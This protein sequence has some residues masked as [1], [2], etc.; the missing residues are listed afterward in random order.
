MIPRIAHRQ[1]TKQQDLAITQL[2]MP[3]SV[4]ASVIWFA[5]ALR[6]SHKSTEPD[7]ERQDGRS[8]H[9]YDYALNC[10]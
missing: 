10:A 3:N 8:N 7:H 6:L 1:R 5:R 4:F 2:T 9:Q